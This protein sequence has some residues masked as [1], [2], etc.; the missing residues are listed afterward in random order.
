MP[1]IVIVSVKNEIGCLPSPEASSDIPHAYGSSM[2]E[3]CRVKPNSS[4][5]IVSYWVPCYARAA[6][7]LLSTSAAEAEHFCQWQI[8]TVGSITS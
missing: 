2:E 7:Y 8:D 5:S 3:K 1:G 4:F 6:R